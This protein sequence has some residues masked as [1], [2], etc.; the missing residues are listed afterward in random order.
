MDMFEGDMNNCHTYNGC[1]Y[2]NHVCEL[3]YSYRFVFFNL[4]IFKNF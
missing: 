4:L 1:Y 2:Q 3:R